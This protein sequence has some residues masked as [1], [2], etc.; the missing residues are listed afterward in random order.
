M[1]FRSEG[2]LQEW[3]SARGHGRGAAVPPQVVYELGR[4]WYAGRLEVGWAR[5]TAVE[6]QAVFARH[7]LTGGFWDLGGT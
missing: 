5:R 6:A 7:G 2:E 1:A 3:L 4:E